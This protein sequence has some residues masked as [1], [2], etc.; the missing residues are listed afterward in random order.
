MG[1]LATLSLPLLSTSQR[2]IDAWRTESEGDCASTRYIVTLLHGS[3]LNHMTLFTEVGVSY[4]DH[5]NDDLLQLFSQMLPC[6]PTPTPPILRKE[7]RNNTR[8]GAPVAR[9]L[10][11]LYNYLCELF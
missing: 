1:L 2:A 3:L 8:G 11:A 6:S 9:C 4:I 7:P 10:F 5:L